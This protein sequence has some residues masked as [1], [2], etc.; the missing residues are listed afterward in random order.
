[1]DLIKS[2]S[3]FIEDNYTTETEKSF[4]ELTEGK[5][6]FGV[7]AIDNDEAIDQT[8]ATSSFTIDLQDSIPQPKQEVVLT[9]STTN[10]QGKTS[11]IDNQTQELVPVKVQDSQTKTPINNISIDYLDSKD[12]K[13]YY[14]QDQNKRYL[15]AVFVDPHNSEKIL[16][17]GPVV[18]KAFINQ[19]IQGEEEHKALYSWKSEVTNAWRDYAYVKTI[20]K[21]EM[22]E[23]RGVEYAI[24]DIAAEFATLITNYNPIPDDYSFSD[25]IK[26]LDGWK[27]FKDGVIAERWDIY[28]VKGGSKSYNGKT[29]QFGA[30]YLD[31][32]PS[33]IPTLT[34]NDPKVEGSNVTLTWKGDDKTTYDNLS[35]FYTSQGFPQ[36]DLTI[37]LGSDPKKADLKY[38]YTISR[39]NAVA[40]KDSTVNTFMAFKNLENGDYTL[41]VLVQDEVGNKSNIITKN[42]GI[43]TEEEIISLRNKI[44]FSRQKPWDYDLYFMDPDGSDLSLF[45]NHAN[46]ISFSSDGSK[47]VILPYGK[48]GD[49]GIYIMDTTTRNKIKVIEEGGEPHISH[50]GTKIVFTFAQGHNNDN[51]IYL[52]DLIGGVTK[53][54]I[55][56]NWYDGYPSFSPNGDK[57]LFVSSRSQDYEYSFQIY[58]MNLD[59]TNQE[60]LT[61]ND[62]HQIAPFFS[63]DGTKIVFQGFDRTCIISIMDSNGTNIKQLTSG[64]EDIHPSWSPDGQKIIFSRL[65]D[66][67]GGRFN[68]E[69]HYMDVYGTNIKRLTYTSSNESNAS[70][71]N[72]VW[73][74]Y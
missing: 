51:E 24:F 62:I 40:F 59:G 68:Y 15:P 42:F 47:A 14:V 27:Y 71:H 3:L 70:F 35:F 63:P 66:R 60:K 32:I 30:E 69:I 74:P 29:I 2:D 65:I 5:Y 53:R 49:K 38:F 12:F 36:N 16:E 43:E 48:Y 45:M 8:P 18:L 44:F 21:D 46:S 23:Q 72:P 41:E 54:L 7:A 67:I 26:L 34:L 20:S 31:M 33:N 56:N 13:A 6:N 64:Y 9:T 55:N 1:M 25:L 11:F 57:I 37:T 61:K 28:H 73:S 22:L 50:D 4:S 39:N 58:L 17:V 52:F 10:E 19:I